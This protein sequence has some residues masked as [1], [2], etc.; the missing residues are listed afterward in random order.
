MDPESQ[1]KNELIEIRGDFL[2]ARGRLK[3]GVNLIGT[4]SGL[5]LYA[6]VEKSIVVKWIGKDA[7]GNILP[8][9]KRKILELNENNE[10]TKAKC[11]VCV[12]GPDKHICWVVPMKCCQ[13]GVPCDKDGPIGESAR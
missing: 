5:S 9:T 6:E 13:I 10:Q 3:E 12:T 11:V 7:K 1:V 8:I 2:T 4:A